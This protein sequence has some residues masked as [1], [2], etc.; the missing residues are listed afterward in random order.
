MQR[1]W[2][3]TI[4]NPED[5]TEAGL[6]ELPHERYCS[7]QLERGETGTRHFQGY[8]EFNQPVR[9]TQIK[10]AGGP[11]ARAHLEVRRGTR[12]QAR[13]Y[14]RKEDSRLAGPW[15]RGS[16]TGGGSGARNDLVGVIE[17]AKRTLSHRAVAEA[18]PEQYIRLHR[19]VERYISA[20]DTRQ[21]EAPTELHIL[22]GEPGTGKSRTALAE[23]SAGA[24]SVYYLP[25]G[26]GGNVWWDGYEGQDCVII[27]DFYG[28]LRWDTLL[29]LADRYP[30]RVEVKG[31]STPFLSKRIYITSNKHWTGW[32]NFAGGRGMDPAALQR[33][34]TSIRRGLVGGDDQPRLVDDSDNDWRALLEQERDSS[35]DRDT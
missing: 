3:F 32:Y 20:I 11:W 27:D 24:A 8:V 31:G 21:R 2:C 26:N 1:S 33:R 9:L 13:D 19:G 10:A 14:S 15:E 18:Y 5:E 23:A 6:P 16:W 4:N 22:W 34:I 25:R 28:W 7:W 17:C 12:H 29:R 30:L 35:N